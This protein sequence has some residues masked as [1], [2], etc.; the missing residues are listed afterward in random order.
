MI[1]FVVGAAS[2]TGRVRTVNQDA[3]LTSDGLYAV[4]DGMGGHR[5]GEVASE[6]ALRVLRESVAEPSLDALVAGVRDANTAVFEMA[7]DDPELAGMGTTLCAIGRILT[8]FEQRV[9][10]VNVGDSR[11][12]LYTTEDFTQL[13]EDHSLVE[14]LVRDGQLSPEEAENHPKR[15]ILTRALGIE[16]TVEADTWEVTPGVGDRFLLCSDGLFNEL[17]DDEIAGV[18][19]RLE[20]PTEVAHELIRRANEHGGRDNVT[21]VV[22]DVVESD[23]SPAVV[24]TGASS[25]DRQRSDSAEGVAAMPA[26][27]TAAPDEE[28]R[29]AI[30]EDEEGEAEPERA[31]R[32]TWR[33]GLFMVAMLAL[34]GLVIAAVGWYARNTYF[35]GLDGEEVVIFQGRPGGVLWF[36]PTVEEASGITLDEI[37][38]A[39]LD[40]LEQG[41]DQASIDDARQYLEN[42]QDQIDEMNAGSESTTAQP[43]ASTTTGAPATTPATTP[44]TPG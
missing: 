30:D 37:P 9:A 36:D 20:D 3:M 11:V 40:A 1:D 19:R 23:T 5:G 12:Y 39:E 13:T 44:A 35:V 22:V 33:V 7:A 28:H 27:L 6:Q 18:L 24:G 16:P 34:I 31:R 8:D 14:S 17:N 4:A 29:P 43:E 2:D 41:K 21:C 38:P 26:I 15:N 32:L 25:L 10:V 42:L